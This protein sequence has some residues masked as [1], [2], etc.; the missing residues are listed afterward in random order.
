MAIFWYWCFQTVL[1]ALTQPW[2]ATTTRNHLNMAEMD[3]ATQKK[4]KFLRP[5][6]ESSGHRFE[7]CCTL[8][9]KSV[10]T[11]E[12]WIINEVMKSISQ[13]IRVRPP[14]Q[15]GQIKKVRFYVDRHTNN[16]LPEQYAHIH[17]SINFS[18]VPLMSSFLCYSNMFIIIIANHDILGP[19][20]KY[21]R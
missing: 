9:L 14:P 6:L 16:A 8:V 7:N 12:L 2:A 3:S 19:P 18:S 11:W 20:F 21:F 4:K 15:G 17:I 13:K 1:A 10:V 5:H